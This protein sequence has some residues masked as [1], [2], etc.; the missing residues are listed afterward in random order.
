MGE[1]AKKDEVNVEE[2]L[3]TVS[4][5]ND[6]ETVQLYDGSEVRIYKCKLKYAG[7]VARSVNTILMSLN[8]DS[9]AGAAAIDLN[10]PQILLRALEVSA[11][12]LMDSLDALTSLDRAQVD[13]LDLD[14]AVKLIA[15]VVEVNRDFFLKR[16]MLALN[17]L[18][19]PS[20][21]QTESR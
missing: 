1:A 5:E 14:D 6:N 8:V 12:S 3:D 4:G 13:E 15:K 11:D 7:R 9:L 20:E 17:E 19:P 16:V 10:N 2:E 18:M 21:N